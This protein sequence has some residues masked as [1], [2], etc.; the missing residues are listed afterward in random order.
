[1]GCHNILQQ[2]GLNFVIL[3]QER[4]MPKN[5]ARGYTNKSGKVV[6]PKRGPVGTSKGHSKKKKK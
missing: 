6:G 1:M 3:S 5:T 4:K 2:R